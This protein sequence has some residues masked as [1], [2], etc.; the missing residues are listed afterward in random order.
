MKNCP[1]FVF[2]S[3]SCLKS[4]NKNANFDKIITL[5]ENQTIQIAFASTSKVDFMLESESNAKTIREKLKP[6]EP[7]T[8]QIHRVKEDLAPGEYR[9]ILKSENTL[10]IREIQIVPEDGNAVKYLFKKLSG[11]LNNVKQL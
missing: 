5:A 6:T 11:R 8:W 2:F 1:Q 3:D 10:Y 4:A 7:M 9:I